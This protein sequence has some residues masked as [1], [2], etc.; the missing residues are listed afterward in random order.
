MSDDK[1][2]ERIRRLREQQLGARDP[3]AKARRLDQK[4][5]SRPREKF[6]LSHELKILPA[7]VTWSFWGGVIGLIVGILLGIVIQIS[8][9]VPWVEYVA[10]LCAFWGAVVGFITGRGHDTGKEDWL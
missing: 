2:I 4:L 1:E 6:S 7:K 10:L 9:G 3:R 5:S 8:F